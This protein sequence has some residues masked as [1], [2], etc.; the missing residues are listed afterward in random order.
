[1]G[2]CGWLVML[3]AHNLLINFLFSSLSITTVSQWEVCPSVT[4]CGWREFCVSITF[5]LIHL[6]SSPS[7]HG[8]SG[9]IGIVVLCFHVHLSF[10]SLSHPRRRM[11]PV[12]MLV[13][14]PVRTYATLLNTFRSTYISV[15]SAFCATGHSW[16]VL[17]P[18]FELT[19]QPVRALLSINWQY[20]FQKEEVM[21]KIYL[22]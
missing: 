1:M 4:K 11:K 5:V 8:I 16:K 13:L 18:T 20:M 22:K 19:F 10:P 2:C 3:L 6:W 9:S 17:G 15:L 21:V 14:W 7:C 12:Y